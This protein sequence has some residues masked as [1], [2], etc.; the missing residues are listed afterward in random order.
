MQRIAVIT[1]GEAIRA[2]LQSVGMP[3]APPEIAPARYEQP[4]LEFTES[5]ATLLR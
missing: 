2:V 1:T 3:T 4:E 5:C